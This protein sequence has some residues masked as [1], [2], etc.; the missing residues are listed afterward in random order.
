MTVERRYREAVTSQSPGLPQPWERL[1]KYRQ[2]QRG[3]DAIEICGLD[4][5]HGR[6]SQPRWGWW[7]KHP[8]TQ[9]CRK[10]RQPWALRRNRFAVIRNAEG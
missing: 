8:S 2:P 7:L 9:G 1:P 4:C 10:T 6:W 5:E 3:C